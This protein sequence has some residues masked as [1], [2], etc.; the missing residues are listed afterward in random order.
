M[1]AINALD[2]LAPWLVLPKF[3]LP[4]NFFCTV[5]CDLLRAA[6]NA[7]LFNTQLFEGTTQY[8]AH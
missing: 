6:T 3:Y 2:T 4:Y 1:W 5:L 8:V 7:K